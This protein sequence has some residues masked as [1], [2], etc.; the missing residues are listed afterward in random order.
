MDL[1]KQ[2]FINQ[3]ALVWAVFLGVI[4]ILDVVL[5]ILKRTCNKA[6]AADDNKEPADSSDGK[7]ATLH[8]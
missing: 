2:I 7:L 1:K 6:P 3:S 8:L 4:I 5:Y